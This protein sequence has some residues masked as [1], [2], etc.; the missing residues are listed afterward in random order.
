M[1][2]SFNLP[3]A[4]TSQFRHPT[5]V[6]QR[7]FDPQQ[8]IECFNF[9]EDV[10]SRLLETPHLNTEK[11]TYFKQQLQDLDACVEDIPENIPY[12]QDQQIDHMLC[13]QQIIDLCKQLHLHFLQAHQAQT[14]TLNELK[15][16]QSIYQHKYNHYHQNMLRTSPTSA[17]AFDAFRSMT[18]FKE[19]LNICKTYLSADD[20][21]AVEEEMQALEQKKSLPDLAIQAD[22]GVLSS[23][24]KIFLLETY[25]TMIIAYGVLQDYSNIP[26]DLKPS[27]Q[28]E[29]TNAQQQHQ[30][31]ENHR[32]REKT[33]THTHT[34]TKYDNPN[35]FHT[36]ATRIK[37]EQPLSSVYATGASSSSLNLDVISNMQQEVQA[38]KTDYKEALIHQKLD[39]N[40]PEDK[41]KLAGMDL[42][43]FKK[44]K[45]LLK[46]I[47][48]KLQVAKNTRRRS[49]F[50]SLVQKR[51]ELICDMVPSIDFIQG[52]VINDDALMNDFDAKFAR[53]IHAYT[54]SAAVYDPKRKSDVKVR[55]KSQ[56]ASHVGLASN[57][58]AA[59]GKTAMV[60]EAVG[61]NLLPGLALVTKVIQAITLKMQTDKFE[62]KQQR[63]NECMGDFAS[64]KAEML[65]TLS[66]ACTFI[67]KQMFNMIQSQLLLESFDDKSIK[68]DEASIVKR[69]NAYLV[70]C[71]KTNKIDVSIKLKHGLKRIQ[72]K[73]IAPEVQNDFIEHFAFLIA[74]NVLSAMVD[75]RENIHGISNQPKRLVAFAAEAF[76]K[77][78][79]YDNFSMLTLSSTSS[80]SNNIQ[81]SQ[82]L[83]KFQPFSMAKA[84]IHPN[85]I[86]YGKGSAPDSWYNNS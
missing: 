75:A 36:L 58:L 31:L 10:L 25:E 20:M 69:F 40:K 55:F 79:K 81:T 29:L 43:I 13:A 63:L 26:H 23:E 39:I 68:Y 62:M 46:S 5:I 61:A 3:K 51:Y 27:I 19:K 32:T 4:S 14:S 41:I 52:A 70:Q 66:R 35:S 33:N 49:E 45:E 47:D 1:Y 54:E 37:P 7:L 78:L 83:V 18:T 53:A 73:N 2:N 38:A 86:V 59:L 72:G 6:N 9:L 44:Q 57:V 22:N 12:A 60:T 84:P 85:L 50:T 21:N 71:D 64:N 82:Q 42:I 24:N 15:E 34:Y 28:L 56:Y 11:H 67:F 30:S 65:P 77:Q 74:D 80:D 76:L 17:Y 16:I 8:H 48:A